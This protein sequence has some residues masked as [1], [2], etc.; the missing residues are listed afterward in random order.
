MAVIVPMLKPLSSISTAMFTTI[1]ERPVKIIA[2]TSNA[3]STDSDIE[4]TIRSKNVSC[5]S[6]LG[7]AETTTRGVV[8]SAIFSVCFKNL[9]P[10]V[11]F[12]FRPEDLERLNSNPNTTRVNIF[13][14]L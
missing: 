9:D 4:A 2:E 3:S 1:S 14:I 10:L 12:I 7:F 6:R 8:L 11:S 5:N 13:V